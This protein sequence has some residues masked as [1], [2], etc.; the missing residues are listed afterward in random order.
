MS[1]KSLIEAALFVSSKGVSLKELAKVTGLEDSVVKDIVE[2]LQREYS[3]RDTGLLISKGEEGF[4]MRI[5]PELGEQ[6]VHLVPEADLHKA[7]LKTLAFIAYEQPIKQ[8]NLVKIRGNRVYNYIPR[9]VE[10]GFVEAKPEGRTKI[11]STTKKFHEYFKMDDVKKE[12]SAREEPQQARLE[13]LG[14]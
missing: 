10:M 4:L 5:K 7:V 12:V 13:E 9:L 6:V 11:L 2:Q 8:S 1:E 3:Q 14:G